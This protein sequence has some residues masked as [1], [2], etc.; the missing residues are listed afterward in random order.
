MKIGN[1]LWFFYKGTLTE[2]TV[3]S[4]GRL[5]VKFSRSKHR[6]NLKSNEIEVKMT[7]GWWDSCRY[8][9]SS[10]DASYWME[11][12]LLELFGESI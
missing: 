5:Y 10:E 9:T 4:I 8:F 11:G 2:L 12:R 7:G 3:E 6:L 1:K